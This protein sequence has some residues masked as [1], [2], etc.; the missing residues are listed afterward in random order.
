[1]DLPWNGLIKKAKEKFGRDDEENEEEKRSNRG[2]V[3]D[4]DDMQESSG[5]NSTEIAAEVEMLKKLQK[6]VSQSDGSEFQRQ[7]TMV[8]R[9]NTNFN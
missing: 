9:E 7:R 6:V 2:S 1:M 3:G 4:D 8:M 5:H